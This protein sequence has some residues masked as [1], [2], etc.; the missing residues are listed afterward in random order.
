M[1]SIKKNLKLKVT[2]FQI[3]QVLHILHNDQFQQEIVLVQCP[4][5]LRSANG[6]WLKMLKFS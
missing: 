3:D 4:R 1:T 2:P 5:N 6:K